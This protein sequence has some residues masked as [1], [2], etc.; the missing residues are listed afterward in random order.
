VNVTQLYELLMTVIEAD[1]D[2]VVVTQNVT[3]SHWL[4]QW[5]LSHAVYFIATTLTTIGLYVTLHIIYPAL[6]NYCRNIF[7][8]DN[9]LFIV[10]TATDQKQQKSLSHRLNVNV[11]LSYR[12]FYDIY[13][14]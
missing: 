6:V 8:N 13:C 11:M 9:C 4:A 14:F 2:G 10:L 3:S 12:P 7:K 1:R 5:D